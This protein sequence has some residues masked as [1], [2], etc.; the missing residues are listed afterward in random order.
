MAAH[1]D[2]AMP[3]RRRALTIFG[4]LAGLPLVGLGLPRRAKA[5][6]QLFTWEGTTLGAEASI[7]LVHTSREEAQKIIDLAVA[8][9]GR[10]EAIFS[11]HKPDSELARLNAAGQIGRA[12]V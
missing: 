5:D 3:T 10:L 6:V 11:L 9:V 7:T 8:E 1:R 12:H 2:T 4:A